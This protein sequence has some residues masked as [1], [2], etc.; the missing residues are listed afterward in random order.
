LQFT[1]VKTMRDDDD[2]EALIPWLTETLQARLEATPPG[3]GWQ[4]FA[5]LREV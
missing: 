1:V 5:D 2:A 3:V 4:V